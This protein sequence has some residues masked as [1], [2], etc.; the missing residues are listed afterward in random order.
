MLTKTKILYDI[1]NK[2]VCSVLVSGHAILVVYVYTCHDLVFPAEHNY[3]GSAETLRIITGN[4]LRLCF[5][6]HLPKS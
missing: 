1:T 2:D 4:K 5:F 6:V 3:S